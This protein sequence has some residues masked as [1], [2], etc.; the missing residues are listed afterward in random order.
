MPFITNTNHLILLQAAKKLGIKTK[1]IQTKPPLVK[2]SYQNQT[3]LIKEK[4]FGLNKS[5]KAKTIS[6]S[7][8]LTLKVLKKNRLPV[9]QQTILKNPSQYTSK[10]ST[11][12]FPQVIKPLYG[13]KGKSVY[14]NIKNQ[15]QSQPA[16]N[17]VLK[18]SPAFGH[19]HSS[20]LFIGAPLKYTYNP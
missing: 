8:S 16:V 18:H 1:I 13:E 2:F 19:I 15:S 4:S 10:A 12:P 7:K 6:R 3:H 14:L 11:I 17:Q 20:L 9:P 5:L